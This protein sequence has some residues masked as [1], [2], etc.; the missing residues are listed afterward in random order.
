M[1][2]NGVSHRTQNLDSRAV[3]HSS[4]HFTCFHLI[5]TRHFIST[6][7]MFY[8]SSLLHEAWRVWNLTIIFHF[9]H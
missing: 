3:Y 6:I 7:L 1:A 5:V 8:L 4:S 2:K 9:Y